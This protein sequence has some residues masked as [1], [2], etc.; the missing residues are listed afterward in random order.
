MGNRIE[1]Y[2]ERKE[3]RKKPSK[4]FSSLFLDNVNFIIDQP[5]KCCLLSLNGRPVL[6]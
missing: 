4:F 2:T 5:F 6:S 3:D 1:I